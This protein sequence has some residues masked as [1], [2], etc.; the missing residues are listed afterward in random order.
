MTEKKNQLLIIIAGYE[1]AL[2]EC[3]FSYNE[4]LNRRFPFRY[5][6][7]AYTYTELGQIFCKMVSEINPD[8]SATWSVDI[9]TNKLDQFFKLNYELFPNFGGDIESFLLGVKIQHGIRVFCLA[10]KYKKKITLEDLE[11]ALK[12][13]RVNKEIKNKNLNIKKY[14]HQSM[15]I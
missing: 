8:P 12:I 9:V 7:D 15:Y 3:F 14:I 13:Y 5:T 6:I 4:G 10:F 1:N 2:E 11:N